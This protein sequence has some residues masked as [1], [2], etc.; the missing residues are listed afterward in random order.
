MNIVKIWDADYPW[1]VRVEKI[2]RTLREGGHDVHLVCRNLAGRVKTEE[3]DGISVH[4]LPIFPGKRLNYMLQFPFFLNPIWLVEIIRIARKIR[5]DIIMVRDLPMAPAAV[6]VGKLLNI[7][8]VFD[9]AEDYPAMLADGS[10]F[11][12]PSSFT[13]SFVRNPKLAKLVEDYVLPRVS[14]ILVVT[15]ELKEKTCSRGINEDKIAVVS[16]TPGLR[17]VE[18][19]EQNSRSSNLARELSECY[20]I[21]YHGG[22]QSLRGLEFVIQALPK[23]L[24]QNINAH[25]YIFGQGNKGLFEKLVEKYELSDNVHL[26]GW[27]P[28]PDIMEAIGNAK[29]G[30][31][32]HRKSPHTDS[33]VPNKIFD[34][35]AV[36]L[37]VVASDTIP[38]SRI[39]YQ[40][41]CGEIFE[42]G[43]INSLT[44]VLR[45]FYMDEEYR[46][47]CGLLGKK[48]AQS[49]YNWSRNSAVLLEAIEQINT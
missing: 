21:V 33:T 14:R 10:L 16:N 39:V 40:T 43:N 46:E 15:E 12:L 45:R 48:A 42:S 19:K 9:M 8:T 5:A 47:Q 18:K 20:S 38:M 34:Y 30:V 44:E 37:P 7:P 49:T 23:L 17:A 13:G 25:F 24:D 36:G 32:P 41:R 6:I 35:M 4:R 22:L 2:T 3:I 1:D 29:V 11:G 31:I 27:W 28:L 26:M